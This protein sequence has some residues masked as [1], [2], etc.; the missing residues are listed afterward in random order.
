MPRFKTA[1]GRPPAGLYNRALAQVR[2]WEGQK[3]L[4]LYYILGR[5]SARVVRATAVGVGEESSALQRAC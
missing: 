4:S 3:R 1:R 5:E 2:Q